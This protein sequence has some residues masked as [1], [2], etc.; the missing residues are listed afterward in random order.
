[1]PM[2]IADTRIRNFVDTQKTSP[3]PKISDANVIDLL[4]AVGDGS[5]TSFDKVKSELTKPGITRGQQFELAKAGLSKSE[6]S[7]IGQLLDKSGLAMDPG[8]KNFLEALVGRAPLQ[9]SFGP[10]T[11]TGDQKNGIAGIA[12]PGE[13]IEAINLSTAPAGR[14]H[15]VDTQV[16]GTA[17]AS[18]KFLGTLPDVREGDMIRLRTRA[19]DGSTSDWLTIQ[20][21][22][23]ETSDT[24]NAIVNL[25]RMDLVAGQSGVAVTHNTGRPITEPGAQIRFVNARTGEK[26]DV[27][28]NEKGSIPAGLTLPG[29]AGDEFKVSVSDGKNNLNH[30]SVTGTLKVPGGTTGITGVDLP[31][32][33]MHKDESN[34]DGTPKFKTER[35]VGPLFIDEPTP[36]DVRQGAIGNCY[37]PAA[38]AAVAHTSPQALKDMVKQNQDGTYTV[39]FYEN[40]NKS[41]PVEVKVDGDLYV[42]SFGGPIYGSSL[43]GT[44]TKDKM[45]LWFP[46]IEK[47]Y[48][49]WKG[50]Y[51]AIGNGGSAGRVMSEVLGRSQSYEWV[52]A[53][54]ED[55]LFNRIKS[56]IAKGIPVA[57]GTHGSDQAS[58][59]TNTGVYANHAYSILGVEEKNGEKFVK[60][61]NPWGQSEYGNDGKN[62]GFFSLPMKKF[63]ELY[64]SMYVLN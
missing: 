63:T 19:A 35:F 16:I 24:R 31:D 62:D 40:G 2:R 57:A 13:V 20:A 33:K 47:A 17:D 38:M 4:A 39:R 5:R 46:I 52:S 14:L 30:A 7:D 55:R 58:R 28:A 34:A 64:S 15:L 41:R 9:E 3:S 10:L 12:K 21:K 50:S 11:I 53:G 51:D 32:P 37:F 6:K 49:Q 54:S 60:L 29:K 42:R 25:E 61:R 22:G 18:G 48:A 59:Y 23:I 1:M 44:N 56:D 45:E 27:T 43:G 26:V 36:G 8:A